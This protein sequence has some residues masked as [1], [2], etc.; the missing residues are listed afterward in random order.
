MNWL[1]WPFV[2][3]RLWPEI[4]FKEKRAIAREE[5]QRVADREQNP[6]RL[7]FYEFSLEARVGIE[8]VKPRKNTKKQRLNRS[9]AETY[10]NAASPNRITLSNAEIKPTMLNKHPQIPAVPNTVGARFGARPL[11]CR[12]RSVR[13]FAPFIFQKIVN[14]PQNCDFLT[15][16]RE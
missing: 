16:N 1:P 5:H 2:P 13:H 11:W 7:A 3:K 10:L 15:I 6:E 12:F 9:A 8:Q 14:T 4:K